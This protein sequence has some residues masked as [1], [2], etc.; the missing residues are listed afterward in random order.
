MRAGHVDGGGGYTAASRV[1]LSTD[2]AVYA[3]DRSVKQLGVKIHGFFVR[4]SQF[5]SSISNYAY[6]VFSKN[7]IIKIN[8]IDKIFLNLMYLSKAEETQ[9]PRLA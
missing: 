2:I 1:S 9:T 5:W 4:K 3:L 7:N 6:F 8:K